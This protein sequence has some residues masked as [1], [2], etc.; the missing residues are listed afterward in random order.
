MSWDADNTLVVQL[1]EFLEDM[2]RVDTTAPLSHAVSEHAVAVAGR[3]AATAHETAVLLRSAA[4][5]GCCVMGTRGD[6]VC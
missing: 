4:A 2:L 6:L 5:V 1:D 3:P